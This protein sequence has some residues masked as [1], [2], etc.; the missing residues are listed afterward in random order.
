M[1]IFPSA[2]CHNIKLSCG[3]RVKNI[4]A[5]VKF[6]TMHLRINNNYKSDNVATFVIKSI[7]I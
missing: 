7:P 1:Q 5:K 6:R 3:F 2:I 4:E